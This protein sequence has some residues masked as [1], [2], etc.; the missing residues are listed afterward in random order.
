MCCAAATWRARPRV[1]RWGVRALDRLAAA[2]DGLAAVR[3]DRVGDAALGGLIVRLHRQTQRVEALRLRCVAGTGP[4]GCGGTP[5]STVGQ[6]AA[7]RG[8]G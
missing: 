6:G 4:G 8:A 2:L 5:T 7:V 3:L 1:H